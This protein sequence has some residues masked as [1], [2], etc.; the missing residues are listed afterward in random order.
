MPVWETEP[1]AWLPVSEE[2]TSEFEPANVG[3][4]V[5]SR[6]IVTVSALRTVQRNVSASPLSRTVALSL[7]AVKATI[8]ATPAV[9]V[10]I[11]VDGGHMPNG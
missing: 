8:S 7:L 6:V 11:A 3:P 9:I 1:K 4:P 2:V 10:L 5:V